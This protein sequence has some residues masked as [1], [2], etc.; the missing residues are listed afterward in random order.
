MACTAAR[1]ASRSRSKACRLDQGHTGGRQLNAPANTKEESGAKL[2]SRSR[3]AWEMAG[4]VQPTI[5]AAAVKL[6]RSTTSQKQREPT[7]IHNVSLSITK[8]V[9]TLTY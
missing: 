4:W 8:V 5:S 2:V 1:L 3:M 7:G 9:L 6:P